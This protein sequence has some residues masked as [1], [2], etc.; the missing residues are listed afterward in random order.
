MPKSPSFNLRPYGYSTY[1]TIL[2]VRYRSFSVCAPK[3]WNS[4]P[5]HIKSSPSVDV[6]KKR[7]KRFISRKLF[8]EHLWLLDGGL[9]VFIL[10]LFYLFI[11]LFIFTISSHVKRFWMSSEKALYKLYK[12]LLI[13]IV[14]YFLYYLQI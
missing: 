13:I 3:V 11:Y 9:V 10:F 5:F 6:L 1:T 7:L 4:L 14:N 12:L 2:I 8:I